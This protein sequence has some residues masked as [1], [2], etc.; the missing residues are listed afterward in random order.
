MSIGTSVTLAP[1]G[2]QVLFT[3]AVLWGAGAIA[4]S[5]QP[6]V[7]VGW[8]GGL[9]PAPVLHGIEERALAFAVHALA[10]RA[11]EPGAWVQAG[12]P[13]EPDR[14]LFSPRIKG[15]PDPAAWTS[16]KQAREAQLD[17]LAESAAW[18]DLR[19]L[20]SLGQPS[21]WHIY[22]GES[23]QDDAASRLEMQPRNQG[24]EFV[25][26][27]LRSLAAAVAARTIDMVAAGL[28]GATRRDEGGNDSPDSRSAANLRPP[29][30][31]DNALA[32]VAMW[33]LSKVPVAHLVHRPSRTATHLP[34]VKSHGLD[35]EVRAGH[36]VVPMWFGRWTLPRLAAVL[37]SNALTNRG[38]ASLLSGP[39]SADARQ[40]EQWLVEHGVRGIVVL[41]IHTVGSKSSPERRA[42]A[43]SFVPLGR[44]ASS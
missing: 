1:T 14:A 10:V 20:S 17:A 12:L 2:H 36:V 15:L 33:G 9:S 11:S 44:D 40:D 34:W 31:T 23:R 35:A 3:H 18:L 16:L 5:V 6:G 29:G 37:A 13:H 28:T 41:P 21:P 8:T 19:L 24:S 39:V 32:W 27:R 42:M 30:V 43:G 7:S 22:K 25:G 26:T 38:R 4:A